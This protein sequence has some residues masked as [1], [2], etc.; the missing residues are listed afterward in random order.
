MSRRSAARNRHRP[1]TLTKAVNPLG[2]GGVTFDPAQLA[3]ILHAARGNQVGNAV[4]LPRTDPQVPFGPGIPLFPQPVNPV[5]PATGRAEPRQREFPVSWNLP[6]FSDRLVPWTVLRAAADQIPLFRRCIEIRKAEVATLE[7]DIVISEKAIERAQQAAGG[8]SRAEVEKAMRERVSPL[9]GKYVDFWETPDRGQGL[10]FIPWAKKFLE[11]HFVLDGVAIYP[12]RT[13]GDDLFAL[14][15]LDAATIKLLLDQSGRRPMPPQP[16]YQQL[17]YGFPRGEF[18]ADVDEDGN[19]PGAYPSDQLIYVIDNVRSHT[20]YG[21]SAVEQALDDGDLYL[22]RHGWMKAE[23]SEG[24]MPAGWLRAGIGQADW[25][26]QQLAQ[27]ETQLNDYYSGQTANR[28]R[29]RIL[30]YGME[31]LPGAEIADKYRPDY[32]LHLIKLVASHFDTT[33]AELGFTET[34]GL[35]STGWHEG[36]ADVQDRK[37]TQPTLRLLQSTI[38]QIS[39]KHL[40]MPRELEFRILGLEAEDEDSADE[41][42]DRRISS[43]R[44][45]RNEDRDRQGLARFPFPEADMPSIVTQ[46]GIVY[47]EG[48]SQLAP[49]GELISPP[50]PAP[51]TAPPPVDE[52]DA[53]DTTAPPASA[54]P[55]APHPVRPTSKPAAKAGAPPGRTPEVVKAEL[56]AYRRWA[57][58]PGQRGVFEFAT[59]TKAEAVAAGVDLPR[60][61]FKAEAGGAR[62]KVEWAAWT[63][64]L[65]VADHYAPLLSPALTGRLNPDAVAAA[66]LHAR[67]AG[68]VDVA[69]AR[70]WLAARGVQ[71][72]DAALGGVLTD[73]WTEGYAVGLRSAAQQLP[74]RVVAKAVGGTVTTAVDWGSWSPGDVNAARRIITEDGM[75]VG[76][77]RLLA[78]KGITIKSL[79]QKSLDDLARVLADGIEEGMS[80]QQLAK[81]IRGRLDVP[82]RAH[83]IAVTEMSRAVSAAT[84]DSYRERGVKATEWFTAEDDRVCVICD[85]NAAAGAVGLGY[86]YPSGDVMP[87]AHPNCRCSLAPAES[88]DLDEFEA[89]YETE[90]EPYG[91]EPTTEP[92]AAEP[93]ATEPE[94]AGVPGLPGPEAAVAAAMGPLGPR[95]VAAMAGLP[96]FNDGYVRVIDIANALG[97]AEWP[98]VKDALRALVRSGA[99]RDDYSLIPTGNTGVHFLRDSPGVRFRDS[100]LMIGDKAQDFFRIR[101]EGGS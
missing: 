8:Q 68:P 7:W 41:V 2:A 59:I 11:D 44:M 58:K 45:T 64:D 26:P 82:A 98:A 37:A 89:D 36:Q 80:P 32:D 9:I 22:R 3:A 62:P 55:A 57:A 39:R 99:A 56:A 1:A 67:A 15:I 69:D 24:T 72:V 43:G 85:G 27:Y 14:E 96:T 90:E 48:S 12:R 40:G 65:Q 63:V 33:I 91:E 47:L 16:A 53:A 79:G 34:G 30:P 73:L 74:P 10:T 35:G 87:P 42:A 54:G 66:W 17:L 52:S 60:A 92:A 61:V 4:P 70:H 5:N 20:T 6:G 97:D 86:L 83:M 100:P 49:P 76:L 101:A 46:R 71:P 13:L 75:H 94:L 18:V 50:Q 95:I 78:A 81:A 21:Y 51:N 19:I 88:D 84:L 31:P 93:A 38:T 23:Y 29:Q 77:Q 28:K 25:S